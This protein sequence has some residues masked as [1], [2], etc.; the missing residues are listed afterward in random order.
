MGGKL[1]NQGRTGKFEPV[2]DVGLNLGTWTFPGICYYHY[3]L[4]S[5]ISISGFNLRSLLWNRD[6]VDRS[7][8]LQPAIGAKA[9]IMR[10]IS[11]IWYLTKLTKNFI[12]HF[13][14][15]CQVFS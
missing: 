1:G 5:G 12:S 13:P 14:S 9:D 2:T 8:W 15:S 3:R 7:P 10:L 11:Q 6:M 4:I